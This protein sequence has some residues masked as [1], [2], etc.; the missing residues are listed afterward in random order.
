LALRN[1]N[2]ALG[3]VML[4]LAMQ[5]G[6]LIPAHVHEGVTK[7]LFVSEGDFIN[8]GKQHLPGTSL[9]VKNGQQRGLAHLREGLQGPGALDDERS[10]GGQP[11]RFHQPP[12]RHGQF[13]QRINSRAVGRR[14]AFQVIEAGTG[15][16]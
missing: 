10:A 8:E 4:Q 6:S 14:K 5:P 13:V 7:V 12:S 16:V 9:H 3:P 15:P 11:G 1:T 2:Y